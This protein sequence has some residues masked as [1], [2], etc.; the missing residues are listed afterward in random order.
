MKRRPRFKCFPDRNC[1]QCGG[2]GFAPADG[3][4]QNGK[5]MTGVVR[6]DCWTIIDLRKPKKVKEKVIYD[7]RAA[8]YVD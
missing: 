5:P 8:A 2:S 1:P 6:C 4:S 7:G 3:I